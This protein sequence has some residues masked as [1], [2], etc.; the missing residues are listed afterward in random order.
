MPVEPVELPTAGDGRARVSLSGCMGRVAA[1]GLL[2]APSRRPACPGSRRPWRGPPAG[3]WW[4]GGCRG[5]GAARRR[6][7]AARA[8]RTPSPR[9]LTA[10]TSGCAPRSV[11]GTRREPRPARR[12]V[13]RAASPAHASPDGQ[14]PRARRRDAGRL[15]AS[16]RGE[17][18]DTVR[19]LRR[20]AAIPRDLKTCRACARAARAAADL[21]RFYGEGQRR[22]GVRWTVLAAVNFVESAFGRV[23][24][25]ARPAPEGPMQFLPSTWRAFGMGGDI[26]DPQDRSSAPRTPE[27]IRL[28]RRTSTARCFTST[29]PATTSARSARSPRGCAPASAPS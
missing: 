21:R 4:R 17:A 23:R 15:P 9:T 5:T 24:V 11:A 25:P 1:A 6:R 28:P 20:L 29:P 8:A 3:R 27:P 14:A 22:F 2:S 16:M 10:T 7:R 19:G 12:H 26:D 18:A 13:P